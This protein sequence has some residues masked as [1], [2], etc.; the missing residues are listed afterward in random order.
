MCGVTA[1][2]VTSYLGIP[3]AAPP[4]GS[5][6][7]QP[8][9]AARPWTSTFEATVAG[10]ICPGPSVTGGPVT[11]SEDCLN[12]NVQVPVG[13][14]SARLPVMVEIH[15]GGF[16]DPI[17]PPNG[18]HLVSAGHVV[19]VAMNYRLGILG[20]MANRAL[21]AHSGDYG[22]QD[23]QASLRWV[24]QNIAAF[25]GNPRNVTILGQSAGGAS[26]CAQVASPTAKG[27]FKRGIPESG[28]YNA[29]VGPNR[30]W[31]PADCKSQIPTQR[32]AESAG[33]IFAAK[34]GCRPT[35][36]RCL[37]A[38]PADKLVAAGGKVDNPTASGTSA[39]I[40]PTI[41]GTTLPMSPGKAFRTG[42]INKVSLMNGVDRDEINGGASLTAPIANT[43]SEFYS[44]VRKQYKGLAG[45]VLKIYPL[46]RF[47]SP[48]IAYR[49]VVADSDS[50]CPAITA[51]RYLSK[52]IPVYA[53]END[54]ADM[55]LAYYPQFLIQTKPY[56]AYHIAADPLLF[57]NSSITLSPDQAALAAQFTAESVGYSR[58]GNPTAFRTPFWSRFT[59]ENQ[60]IMTL[61]P[62]GDS[63]LNTAAT[64]SQQ[65]HCSFWDAV[66][67]QPRS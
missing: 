24:Q 4:V 21:G 25:G 55:P 28:F 67:P 66:R 16:L 11:G 3:Y 29:A 60:S 44:Q 23:Q 41:N 57:P 32:Q 45:R 43:A 62:A 46:A 31:E 53:W 12:L 18:S 52:Y 14:R 5:L 36:V 56:G 9:R 13:V 26:V 64:I 27:L 30:V 10:N 2:G 8:P 6:R 47:P 37:R 65:H 7:W 61:V 35:D 54:D 58:T 63:V 15:G 48:F 59:R 1:G 39:T 33:A 50:V 17:G 20:F 34:V 51:D 49:T 38:V 19:Y 40:A 22:L 42:H